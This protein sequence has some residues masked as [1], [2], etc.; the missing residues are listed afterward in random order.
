M[1]N[2]PID[3]GDTRGREAFQRYLASLPDGPSR[4]E[5]RKALQAAINAKSEQ[6]VGSIWA[7]PREQ[8]GSYFLLLLSGARDERSLS[9]ALLDWRE[10]QA[11]DE[12]R[13]RCVP[14]T[15]L[16]RRLATGFD[17]I[18]LPALLVG[19]EPELEDVVRFDES[20]LLEL[21][22]S[23]DEFVRFI[24]R[25][26]K[27]VVEDPGL[28]LLRNRLRKETVFAWLR[29]V[30]DEVKGVFSASASLPTED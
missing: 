16:G 18:E 27:L 3:R 15:S 25:V 26:H 9:E 11:F 6:T 13:V 8:T 5:A 4:E 22:E 24:T 29:L 30:Y 1:G 12:A 14:P 2:E 10:F 7:P 23:P 17:V 20:V 28:G 21:A 19:S